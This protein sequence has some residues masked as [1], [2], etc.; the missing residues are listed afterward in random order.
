MAVLGKDLLDIDRPVTHTKV[1][2]GEE[3]YWI[4]ENETPIAYGEILT[5]ILN[6]D[7]TP[8]AEAMRR[9]Q[10]GVE[11]MDCPGA[12]LAQTQVF[13]EFWKLPFYERYFFDRENT[14][15]LLVVHAEGECR[16]DAMK[17][18]LNQMRTTDQYRNA[19]EDIRFI[20]NRY[21][22][23][24]DK[25]QEDR[26]YEK[27]K[28][29]RKQP[30]AD[31][32]AQ[33][34]LEALVSGA[35]LDE[36]EEVDAPAVNIQYMVRRTGQGNELV[37][38]LYFNR[39]LDFAYVELMRGMQKG[40]VP[41]R[42]A[43]CGRWF[44]QTP[45]A[46]FSY[47]GMIAPGETEKTCRDV[48]ALTSFQAKVRNNEIWQTHQRAYKKYYARV[49]K[50]KMSKQEFEIW[51]RRAEQ[52]RDDALCHVQNLSE[53]KREQIVLELTEKLNET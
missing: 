31:R 21:R 29:Q 51:A 39:I 47:C 8:Y 17:Y 10:E 14:L 28:G 1:L 26:E 34:Y 24:L 5:Q 27:K 30:L 41:K 16:A 48:G 22:W 11:R 12:L 53:D 35:C 37:E 43:N 6:Y 45:G 3:H 20:Q 7:L 40:F 44:L 38:K 13:D 49:L 4:E 9:Y 19:L 36:N 50:K 33:A 18:L 52:L 15:A 46:S 42:C 2:F 32:M 23:F 25:L